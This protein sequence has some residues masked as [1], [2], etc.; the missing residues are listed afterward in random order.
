MTEAQIALKSKC[1]EYL[2]SRRSTYEFRCNRYRAAADKL[3]AIGFDTY[4]SL[5]DVGAGSQDFGRFMREYTGWHGLYTP[6]DGAINGTDLNTWVPTRR[7]DYYACIEVLEHVF[8]PWRLIRVMEWTCKH[9]LV[10]TTPNSDVVDTLNID[11]THRIALYDGDFQVLGYQTEIRSFFA[12]END[13]ILAW[14]GL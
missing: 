10:Y 7:T 6:I 14:K 2:A 12:K 9:G 4:S 3:L 5:V 11:P 1:E 13:S 8:D